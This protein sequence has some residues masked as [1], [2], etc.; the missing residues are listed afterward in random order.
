VLLGPDDPLPSAPQRVLVNGAS[1]SG[2]TTLA[3]EVSA[4]LGLP[5][6]EIDALHHGPAWQPRPEFLDDVRRLAGSERWVAEWQYAAAR[7]LLLERADLLVWLDLPRSL[8]MRQVTVRTLRRRL[9]REELWNGNR[10]GP[11]WR[12]LVDDEHII[13]W[14]WSTWHRATERAEAVLRDRPALP[15]VRLRSRSEVRRWLD[16]PLSARG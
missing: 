13:R 7:P 12:I 2:K 4:R 10:E 14:A 8:V 1:G 5:H 15:V 3:R 11:L 6:T 9:R 16:G